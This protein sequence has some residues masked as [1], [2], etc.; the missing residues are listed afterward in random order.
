MAPLRPAAARRLALLALVQPAALLRST[1]RLAARP[2]AV[3]RPAVVRMMAGEAAT[4][5]RK[6]AA[7]AQ[8]EK[9]GG[10]AGRG[11]LDLNPPRGTR[12]F[13][14]EEMELRTWLFDAWRR[15][16]QLHGFEEYDAPV[17]ESVE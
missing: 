11:A 15:E 12:D 9:G 17:L 10:G 7:V 8:G 2:E 16:A 1:P 5:G 6:S 4:A 3:G 14:P 13:Y